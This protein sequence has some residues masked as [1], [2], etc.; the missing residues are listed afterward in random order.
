MSAILLTLPLA[1]APQTNPA[2]AAPRPKPRP[3]FSYDYIQVGYITHEVEAADEDSDGMVF[4]ASYDIAPH[5]NLVAGYG[6]DRL[7]VSGVDIDTDAFA[8]GAG[9][10]AP[11]H[12]RID[13]YG[14][15]VFISS[16]ADSQGVSDSET[17]FGVEA[18][19]RTMPIDHVE[20]LAA[21]VHT[22]VY[23]SS[24]NLA[25]GA[26]GYFTDDFSLGFDVL[27]D[28]AGDTFGINL[29]YGF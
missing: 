16:E 23:E 19:F 20:I 4:S 28:S 17:G 25:V 22:D 18:G 5:V 13:I 6:F 15:A 8:V 21:A 26:R 11:L 10:H 7:T 9:A 24:T 2:P 14:T 3:T 29:R 12:Q 1:L 27:F